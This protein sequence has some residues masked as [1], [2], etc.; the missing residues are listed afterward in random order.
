VL[1]YAISNLTFD[2]R[3]F[4]VA[5]K[6][7]AIVLAIIAAVILAVFGPSLKGWQFPAPHPHRNFP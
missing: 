7:E 3:V 1:P 6:T 5:P 4:Q 2:A